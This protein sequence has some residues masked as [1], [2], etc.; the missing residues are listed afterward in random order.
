[1]ILCC[2]F[3]YLKKSY[4]FKPPKIEQS[5]KAFPIKIY[6]RQCCKFYSCNACC[7]CTEMG[8]IDQCDFPGYVKGEQGTAQTETKL[9]FVRPYIGLYCPHLVLDA[10]I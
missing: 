2:K 7:S 6:S 8:T 3:F 4:R 9:S 5:Y 1:M 10:S